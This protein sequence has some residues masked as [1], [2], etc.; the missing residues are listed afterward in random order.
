MRGV[1]SRDRI[2]QLKCRGEKFAL[3]EFEVNLRP[4][5][6]VNPHHIIFLHEVFLT[7]KKK[8]AVRVPKKVNSCDCAKK[9]KSTPF[10]MFANYDSL[11]TGSNHPDNG[12]AV[13]LAK[14]RV[15]INVVCAGG[16][17]D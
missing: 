6:G 9:A 10:E 14:Y 5:G 11:G 2:S 8:Y 15:V 4:L 16:A 12:G 3:R 17:K 13:I 1:T 7:L